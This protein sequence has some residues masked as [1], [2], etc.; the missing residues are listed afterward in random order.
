MDDSKFNIAVAYQ[1]YAKLFNMIINWCVT[2]I[3]DSNTTIPNKLD[4]KELHILLSKSYDYLNS[5]FFD[6][7]IL[8]DRELHQKTTQELVYL[9]E[10]LFGNNIVF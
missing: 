6:K 1:Q 9:Y 10:K 3:D 2:D 7:N 8:I 5:P 4:K